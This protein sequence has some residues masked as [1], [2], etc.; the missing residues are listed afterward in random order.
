[1]RVSSAI[2]A[3][4]IRST[5]LLG[6]NVMGDSRLQALAN[7]LG[8]D[9]VQVAVSEDVIDDDRVGGFDLGRDWK[10]RASCEQVGVGAI[11]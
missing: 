7:S 4:G 9:S 2:E 8:R 1:M 3:E 11:N 6:G 10:G 5:H